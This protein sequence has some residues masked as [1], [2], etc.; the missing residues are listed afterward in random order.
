MTGTDH[1]EMSDF[2]SGD[3]WVAHPLHLTKAELTQDS[4][5]ECERPSA[6]QDEVQV[7][8]SL[9]FPPSLD[10]PKSTSQLSHELKRRLEL[11]TW[12]FFLWIG[13]VIF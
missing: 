8:V 11:G 7:V 12:A 1:K 9:N 2:S 5:E 3:V 13:G 6:Y 4:A 10:P